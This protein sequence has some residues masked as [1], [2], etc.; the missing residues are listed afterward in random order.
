MVNYKDLQFLWY[1]PPW[2]SPSKVDNSALFSGLTANDLAD[3]YPLLFNALILKW[4]PF[5][6]QIQRMCISAYR[7]KQLP[8]SGLGYGVGGLI[9]Q[10][11]RFLD[12]MGTIF[13]TSTEL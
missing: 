7:F 11:F 13:F 6:F 10:G 1:A 4:H 3:K 5:R 8:N 12:R 9:V 2:T